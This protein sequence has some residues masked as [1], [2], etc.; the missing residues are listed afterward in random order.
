MPTDQEET[1]CYQQSQKGKEEAFKSHATCDHQQ[2]ALIQYLAACDYRHGAVI[3][4]VT[5]NNEYL[6]E[7]NVAQGR[8]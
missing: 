7:W 3:Q 4:Q 1:S 6:T 2:G 5:T 8:V